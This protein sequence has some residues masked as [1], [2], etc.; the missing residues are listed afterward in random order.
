MWGDIYIFFHIN[1]FM[2]NG[3]LNNLDEKNGLAK[4]QVGIW[5]STFYALATI[6]PFGVF[7]FAAI[8]VITYTSSAVLAFVAGY[9]ISLV[10]IGIAIPFSKKVTSAGGWGAFTEAGLGKFWGYLTQWA[11]AG[12]YTVSTGALAATTGYLTSVFVS[13]FFGYTLPIYLV[14]LLD[15]STIIFAFIVVRMRVRTMT[16]INSIFGAVEVF[17]AL[18][19]SLAIIVLMGSKN[20]TAAVSIPSIG[21]IPSF[22]V[23]FIVGALGSY[24]GYGTILTLSEESKLPKKYVAKS[25]FITVSLA[26]IVFVVGTYAIIAGYGISR[27]HALVSLT[28]PGY[29]VV[30]EY[31]GKITATFVIILLLIADYGTE[32][33]LLGAASRV[34]YSLARDHILP[35]WVGKLNHNKVPENIAGLMSLVGGILSVGLTQIFVIIYG[36]TD[37]IFYGVAVLGLFGTFVLIFYHITS[38]L[39]MPIFFKKIGKLGIYHFVLPI[40][41]IIVFS[42][43]LYYSLLGIT[44]PL[45]IMPISV[46]IWLLIGSYIVYI[47][48]KE[49]KKLEGL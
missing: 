7:G 46:A 34:Y 13:Y 38:S 26:G 32:I 47:R 16:F 20:T 12:G 35:Q 14:Y 21:G 19:I 49:L 1:I 18:G 36:A 27:L 40:I 25:L 22:F 31:L 28:A 44:M 48:T 2:I 15:I 41:A 24:A 3:K 8:G 45:T 17:A 6:L 5:R 4:N 29:T 9:L 11:Y 43:V 30:G 42:I 37:G 23:G 39:S 10:S 33:G